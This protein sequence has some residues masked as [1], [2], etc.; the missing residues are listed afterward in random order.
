MLIVP[1]EEEVLLPSA[2]YN[3]QDCK[4]PLLLVWVNDLIFPVFTINPEKFILVVTD[5]VSPFCTF[6]LLD[7][8]ELLCRIATDCVNALACPAAYTF[9]ALTYL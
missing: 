5:T 6:T 2:L 3:I 8:P 7:V 1:E 4:F 9:E